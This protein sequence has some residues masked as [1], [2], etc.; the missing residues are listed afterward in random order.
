MSSDK[1]SESLEQQLKTLGQ[2]IRID[3]LKKLNDCNDSISFSML[4]KKVLSTNS[5]S[6]NL[7]FHLNVL[8]KSDL[9][10]TNEYGYSI[11][12]LGKKILTNILKIEQILNVQN[13]SII[14]RTSKYSKEIFDNNKIVEYLIREG[15]LDKYLARQIA[16]EVKERLSNITIEYL[17]APL[18]REYI[19]AILLENG[20]EQVRHKLTRLGTPPYEVYKLFEKSRINPEN[21]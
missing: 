12:E 7:S 19:N 18:M 3:I 13:N 2:K 4:Q 5:N 21:F 14:I 10:T 17:T 1:I 16:Q 20:L 11:T 9:I 8:K 15:E 6:K